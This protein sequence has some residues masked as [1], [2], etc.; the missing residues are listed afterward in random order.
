MGRRLGRGHWL[1]P[2][3]G[4]W[5][6]GFSRTRP[7]QGAPWESP[8]DTAGSLGPCHFITQGSW[9]RAQLTH[10]GLW[11]TAAPSPGALTA[12]RCHLMQ[13][14]G[15]PRQDRGEGTLSLPYTRVRIPLRPGPCVPRF[16][17][18]PSP[19]GSQPPGS[20]EAPLPAGE[21]VGSTGPTHPH[22]RSKS[23]HWGGPGGEPGVCL[24][25]TRPLGELCDSQSQEC[26]PRALPLGPS[27]RD[28]RFWVLGLAAQEG[29]GWWGGGAATS[30]C[31]AHMP[32]RRL[33]IV[34]GEARAR[35]P[36]VLP[37][38]LEDDNA[39]WTC[40]SPPASRPLPSGGLRRRCGALPLCGGHVERRRPPRAGQAA[41]AGRLGQ[42]LPGPPRVPSCSGETGLTPSSQPPLH[43]AAGAE[44][45]RRAVHSPAELLRGVSPS[46]G[47]SGSEGLLV[48]EKVRRETRSQIRAP[49][50]DAT[51][52]V[53]T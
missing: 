1:C 47:G 3:K 13:P 30:W 41:G 15:G 31:R 22:F 42:P 51:A 38:H 45:S 25:S 27:G 7:C 2:P 24:P 33:G 48:W 44:C 18:R 5:E 50:E 26:P 8:H 35:S 29:S 52:G 14:R 11:G 39:G 53:T 32:G 28:P 16:T 46:E 40:P 23:P 17:L 12:T 21:L 37:R 19:L 6:Q 10:G 49:D 43:A 4:P 34:G 9:K 20:P 36:Q